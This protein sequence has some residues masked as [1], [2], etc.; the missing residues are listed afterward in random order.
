MPYFPLLLEVTKPPSGA[1]A[2]SVLYFIHR[3]GIFPASNK[4]KTYTMPK[5]PNVST[6]KALV[7]TKAVKLTAAATKLHS[8]IRIA[9]NNSNAVGRLLTEKTSLK[10]NL[11]KGFC[12]YAGKDWENAAKGSAQGV[13]VAAMVKELYDLSKAKNKEAYGAARKLMT[14]T[15]AFAKAGYKVKA[16]GK[17]KGNKGRKPGEKDAF[18][19]FFEKNIRPLLVRYYTDAKTTDKDENVM[20]HIRFACAEAGLNITKEMAMAPKEEVKKKKTK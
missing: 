18:P 14:D 5:V 2:P 7:S 12:A 6:R 19:V 3:L 4:R 9:V 16:K 13:K 10:E 1:I 17:S 20:E 8:L 11:A 15:R